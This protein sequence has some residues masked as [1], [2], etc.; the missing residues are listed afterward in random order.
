MAKPIKP[1]PYQK[2]ALRS[3][4]KAR[5]DESKSALVV[6]ASG[7]GKTVVAAFTAKSF[8]RTNRRAKVLYLC[9][10]NHILEQARKTFETVLGDKY[11]YGYFHGGEQNVHEVTFLFASFQTMAM[12][13]K[14]FR[15]REFDLVIVDESHHSHAVTYLPTLRYFKPKFMLAVTATPD[16]LDLQDIRD[17]Y[18]QEIFDLPLEKAL[19][20]GLLTKV[21]YRV[22]MDQLVNMKYLKTATGKIS[23]R[24][25][26]K[27]LF[28]KPR[29]EQI[30]SLL[31]EKTFVVSEPKMVIF[32]PST[33]Y[34]DHLAKLL[35]GSVAIHSRVP[36][37]KQDEYLAAFKKGE[38]RAIV[39]VDKF[40]EGID[41]PDT[42]VIVF[43][44]STASKTIFFQQLGRG[45]RHHRGKKQVLVLDFVAN[46][47]R[48]VLLESVWKAVEKWGPSG[49]S[50]EPLSVNMGHYEFDEIARD[51]LDVIHRIKHGYTKEV[52]ISQL[53]ALALKLGRTPGA[54]DVD[55]ASKRGE[56]GSAYTYRAYFG[57]YRAALL[58][59]GFVAPR[60]YPAK[61]SRSRMLG[62]IKAL[63]RKLGRSPTIKDL[64]EASRRGEAPSFAQLKKM[65]G[66]FPK[67]VEAAG[68]QPFRRRSISKRVLIEELRAL[69]KRLGYTP[70]IKEAN[71]ASKDRLIAH[72]QTYRNVFGSWPAAI[73]AA[74]LKPYKRK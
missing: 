5:R 23:I 71:Q 2:Q 44:R 73:K 6:M 4:A 3:I 12:R 30:V 63:A 67:A 33:K 59:A 48:L 7:L 38:Y 19:A 50:E 17:I 40:N 15:P 28:I 36:S 27:K 51:V 70:G 25:L 20:A 41:V 56:C 47:D 35:P 39:T 49:P 32:C 72:P 64:R 62:E 31:E 13:R 1:Y 42:N 21:D 43:L 45:L 26:N 8:L 66:S 16:R 24:A 61:R 29:D 46:C 34:C 57:S 10:Q 9:H 18:G 53:Q 58:A 68:L 54:S 37:A 22:V 11:S 14:K 55:K 74:G 69:C 52:L 65:F 60:Q